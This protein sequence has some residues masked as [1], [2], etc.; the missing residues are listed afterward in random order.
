M[1]KLVLIKDDG[2]EVVIRKGL[3]DNTHPSDILFRD[4]YIA[5]KLWTEE[6]IRCMLHEDGFEGTQEEINEVLW[7]GYHNQLNDCTDTD[8]E[9]IGW[10]VF[11]AEHRGRIKK[12]VIEDEADD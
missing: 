3:S 7:T 11:E 5:M 6:D 12:E 2:S 8:W 10:G 4:D 9:I 1:A